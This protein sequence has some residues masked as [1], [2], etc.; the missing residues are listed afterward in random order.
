M[1]ISAFDVSSARARGVS[2]TDEALVIDLCDGRTVSAPLA[3]FPRLLQGTPPERSRWELLG[4][5]EGIHWPDL[6]EDVSV[7]QVLLGRPS[8]ESQQSLARWLAARAERA[9][10]GK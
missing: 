8:A 7:E 9:G 3:W 6:D 4:A 5:G 1:S 10:G 2:V